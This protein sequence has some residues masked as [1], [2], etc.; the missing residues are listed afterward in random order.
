LDSAVFAERDLLGHSMASF[1]V[2]HSITEK[3]PRTSFV[4]LKGPSVTCGPP[5]LEADAAGLLI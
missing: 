3:P 2:S 4:S 5:G 1:F